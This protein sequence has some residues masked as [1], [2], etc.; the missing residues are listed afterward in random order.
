[1]V[2]SS[3]VL[4]VL[5]NEIELVAF[6]R[7]LAN[8]RKVIMLIEKWNFVDLEV[9]VLKNREDVVPLEFF[10][11]QLEWHIFR[12]CEDT[13]MQFRVID[14]HPQQLVRLV[15]PLIDIFYHYCLN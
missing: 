7:L 2:H 11:Y 1:M 13:I 15:K 10:E 14:T 5:K 4:I 12:H 6:L 9:I 3:G 8:G